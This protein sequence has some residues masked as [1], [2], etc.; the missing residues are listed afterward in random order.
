MAGKMPDKARTAFLRSLDWRQVYI[1]QPI[2]SFPSNSVYT[3]TAHICL[4]TLLNIT[5]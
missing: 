4:H 3:L 2:L 1:R 5:F